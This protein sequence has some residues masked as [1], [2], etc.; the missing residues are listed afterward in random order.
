MQVIE[1]SSSR[2]GPASMQDLLSCLLALAAR[3]LRPVDLGHLSCCGTRDT[4]LYT[5]R[6]TGRPS[7][8]AA[9][10]F[11]Q[12]RHLVRR[13]DAQRRVA[14]VQDRE[15]ARLAQRAQALQREPALLGH[16]DVPAP[17]RR[18]GVGS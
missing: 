1:I 9:G 5:P 12:R 16:R 7:V 4:R 6:V 11:A 18:V 8:A 17:V 13:K 10:R 3:H 14:E 2:V 15:V